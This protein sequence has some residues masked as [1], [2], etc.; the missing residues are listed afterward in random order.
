MPSEIRYKRQ[1]DK[2]LCLVSLLKYSFSICLSIRT[3]TTIRRRRSKAALREIPSTYT[4]IS[5]INSVRPYF[6]TYTSLCAGKSYPFRC[7]AV[8][9]LCASRENSFSIEIFEHMGEFSTL[10]GNATQR[11]NLPPT[12][13]V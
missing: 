3:P 12:S 10:C 8:R 4:I 11:N 9:A 5:F 2:Q 6:P 7:R 1:T 13:Y